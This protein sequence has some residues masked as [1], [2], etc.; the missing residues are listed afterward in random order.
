MGG[1][2]LVEDAQDYEFD[3]S[4]GLNFATV[5]VTLGA[6]HFIVMVMSAAARCEDEAA[7]G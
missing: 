2:A 7:R 5:G 6:E 1:G 4:A 3:E